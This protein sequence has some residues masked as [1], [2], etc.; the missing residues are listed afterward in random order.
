MT[1]QSS[2]IPEPGSVSPD[3]SFEN[4]RDDR[5]HDWRGMTRFEGCA[6][7]LQQLVN[8]AQ[9]SLKGEVPLMFAP[10]GTPGGHSST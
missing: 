2:E 10:V 6:A 7:I 9:R 3:R 5:I 4:C 1:S 8:E